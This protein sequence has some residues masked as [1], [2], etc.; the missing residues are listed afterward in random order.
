MQGSGLSSPSELDLNSMSLRDHHI[1][2]SSVMSLPSRGRVAALS[3]EHNR[4]HRHHRDS[5]AMGASR[6]Q[7]LTLPS[8]S[9]STSMV[10]AAQGHDQHIHAIST[11]MSAVATSDTGG[12]MTE[13]VLVSEC[14]LLCT[15]GGQSVTT[16]MSAFVDTSM[17]PSLGE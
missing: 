6:L 1:G 3:P 9:T 12:A 2:T 13:S 5:R 15:D 7:S 16:Q 4:Q 11:S 8:S 14:D 10:T 17:M